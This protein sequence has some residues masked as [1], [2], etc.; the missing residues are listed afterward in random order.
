M[1]MLRTLYSNFRV[2]ILTGRRICSF[3]VF[4]QL[5]Y[6]GFRRSQFLSN[7]LLPTQHTVNILCNKWSLSGSTMYHKTLTIGITVSFLSFLVSFLHR[8][9]LWAERLGMKEYCVGSMYAAGISQI[10]HWLMKHAWTDMKFQTFVQRSHIPSQQNIV[11][12]SP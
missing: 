1:C 9:E 2:C 4:Y 5:S 12:N 10:S 3:P 11:K 8:A 7:M 6:V